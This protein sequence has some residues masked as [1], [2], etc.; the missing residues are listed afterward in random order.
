MYQFKIYSSVY[1]YNTFLPL[2]SPRGSG[3]IISAV[4]QVSGNLSNALV[5][6]PQGVV[7]DYKCSSSG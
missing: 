4:I 2:D 1:F 7:V 5:I 3:W 6:T